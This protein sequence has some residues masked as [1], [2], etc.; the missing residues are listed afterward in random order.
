[1]KMVNTKLTV[2]MNGMYTCEECNYSTVYK[3]N[4]RKHILSKRHQEN[5]EENV[6][7]AAAAAA[8]AADRQQHEAWKH[9]SEIVK[10]TMQQT[11][12]II[13][14]TIMQT[15]QATSDIL[16]SNSTT[17]LTAPN[18][19]NNNVTLL[20]Q[21]VNNSQTNNHIT[22]E[23]NV[24][25]FSVNVFLNEQCKNAVDISDFISSA[26]V[27]MEDLESMGELGYTAGMTKILSKVFKEKPLS[28]RP[29][30]CTDVKRETIYI[31]K[32]NAW[33]KDTDKEETTQLILKIAHKN[34]KVLQ[35]W[36]EYHPQYSVH[37]TP[38]YEAWYSISRSICNTD[39]AA[40]R[41]LVR[42][43]A[44]TTAVDKE[45]ILC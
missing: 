19:N 7:V 35:K 4:F 22:L 24:T 38:D 16:K 8:A 29:M 18:N 9:Q 1:M 26:M 23:Q 11:A 10:Q 45:N 20:E 34:Y 13:Q 3:G 28:E 15:M 6:I 32:N 39:P 14:Q 44:L 21:T 27:S 41:K 40:I 42:H 25:K 2:G 30:H 36:L 37:D 43:L 12:Q 33:E 17:L 31:R 5:D